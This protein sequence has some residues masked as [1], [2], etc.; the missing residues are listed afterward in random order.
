M[1]KTY[2]LIS[3]TTRRDT[4]EWVLGR[5][6]LAA[7]HETDAKLVPQ[8][9]GN[10]EPIKIPFESVAACEK[11]WSPI[12]VIRGPLGKSEVHS[13]FL[14]KWIK[15]LKGYGHVMHTSTNKLGNM[16][17]GRIVVRSHTIKNISWAQLFRR[18]CQIVQPKF[19]MLHVFTDR[20]LVATEFKSAADCFQ[21]GPP[22]WAMLST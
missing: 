20:E 15:P 14:W 2:I 10:S 16:T 13:N 3:L 19:G 17:L 1:L 22:G 7:L 12:M 5:T 11:H 6:L 8:F 9:V 18:L 4:A 21:N